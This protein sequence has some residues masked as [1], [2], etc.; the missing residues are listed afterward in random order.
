[1]NLKQFGILLVALAVV[2]S[3]C[4]PMTIPEPESPVLGPTPMQETIIVPLNTPTPDEMPVIP[5]TGEVYTYDQLVNDL[6]AA[7]TEPIPTGTVRQPF[8]DVT[9]RVLTVN[10]Q[11]IQVFEFPNEQARQA[12]QDTISTTA[13]FIGAFQPTWVDVPNFWSRGRI[14][15]LFIGQHPATLGQL[16]AIL[17]DRITV[18]PIENG[19]PPVT[20]AEAQ[21]FLS[22]RLGVDISRIQLQTIRFAEWPDACLGLPAADELCAQ[23]ITPGYQLI[24][25]VDGRHY[26]VRTNTTGSVIRIG[27]QTQ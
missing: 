5:E 12:A 26:E 22:E 27:G 11:E 25:Q 2:L 7:G 17:R 15:V 6:I 18:S 9:A 1:M 16:D 24:F 14:L 3:A 21:R 8:F 13:E 10:D 19:A 20:G 23:V 4:V